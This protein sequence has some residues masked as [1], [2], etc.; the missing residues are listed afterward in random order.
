MPFRMYVQNVSVN[1]PK[2]TNLD[3][4]IS[5]LKVMS[6]RDV[7]CKYLAKNLALNIFNWGT[8]SSIIS[9][10]KCKYLAANPDSRLKVRDS[11]C[12]EPDI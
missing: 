10:C 7:N 11:A 1:V 12:L 3:S 8:F 9:I 6:M 5:S 2:A 4:D